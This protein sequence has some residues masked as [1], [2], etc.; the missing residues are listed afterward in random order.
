MPGLDA[1]QATIAELLSQAG[2]QLAA[3]QV[4]Q[5]GYQAQL[6]AAGAMTNLT[7][8]GLQD[9]FQ[10]QQAGYDIGQ[11]QLGIQGAQLGI[12]ERQ[13]ALGKQLAGIQ[14]GNEV[15]Q[16]QNTKQQNLEDFMYNLKNQQGQQAAS[17]AVGAPGQ[18]RDT[19][20]LTQ[21]FQTAAANAALG[22]ASEVAGYQEQYG[23][24]QFGGGQYGL[25]QQQNALAQKNLSLIAQQN[26]LSE[27]QVVEQLQTGLAQNQISG[28][29]SIGQLMASMGNLAAGQVSTA[30]AAIAPISYTFGLNTMPVPTGGP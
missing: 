12:Q 2:P 10:F 27:A 7:A 29:N 25:T 19:A 6:G 20:H 28:V 30:G 22:Q 8:Q 4:Q 16:Y 23:G 13:Q 11:Q 21:N 3:G 14:Q 1:A 24:G 26:G 17:G 5:A 18:A 9:Q 15:Q